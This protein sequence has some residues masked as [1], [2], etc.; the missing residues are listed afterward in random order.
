MTEPKPPRIVP[1][2]ARLD[3]EPRKPT[4]VARLRQQRELKAWQ[5]KVAEQK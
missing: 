4:K 3:V 1:A 5:R 2:V